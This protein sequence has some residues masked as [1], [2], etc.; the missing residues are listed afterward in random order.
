MAD[1]S[2]KVL[3]QAAALKGAYANDRISLVQAWDRT[4]GK[5]L[6]LLCITV[7]ENE[8]KTINLV[9]VAVMIESPPVEIFIPPDEKEHYD[10]LRET[11]WKGWL[12]NVPIGL[13]R[14]TQSEY[15]AVYQATSQEDKETRESEALADRLDDI[16]KELDVR[17]TEER[18]AK[19]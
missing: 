5:P 8:G 12:T 18:K 19:N 10:K 14:A 4:T 2:A 6:S 3:Q 15:L 7:Q 17:T 13:L 9:P 11:D 16:W 1:F